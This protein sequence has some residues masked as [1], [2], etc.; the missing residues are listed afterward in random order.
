[1]GRVQIQNNIFQARLPPYGQVT[2]ACVLIKRMVGGNTLSKLENYTYC[3]ILTEDDFGGKKKESQKRHAAP[4]VIKNDL[5]TIIILTFS[6]KSYQEYTRGK[7][8]I[9]IVL[10][11][12]FS[13]NF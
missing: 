7:L 2:C 12:N 5:I 4:N 13:L 10:A 8:P 6:G 3:R 1:M 11:A 9:T